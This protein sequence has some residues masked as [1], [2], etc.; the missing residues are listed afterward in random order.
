MIQPT[1]PALAAVARCRRKD[2]RPGELIEA[3][4]DV[5][6]ERGYAAA[7]LDDIAQRAGVTK[8]TVYLYFTDKEELFEAVVQKTLGGMVARGHAIAAGHTGRASD[9]LVEI[10]GHWWQDI[11]CDP[12]ASALPKLLI[13]EACNFPRLARAYYQIVIEPGRA[14]LREVLNR[15][16]DSGEFRPVSV[17]NVVQ[18]IIAPLVYRQCMQHSLQMAVPGMQLGDGEFLASF[19][20]HLLASLTARDHV[21]DLQ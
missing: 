1:E 16:I 5:F 21:R 2:A 18:F 19:K 15:G 10:L 6:V 9:L 11:V 12:R 17:D 4:L 13:A 14:L 20:D 7:R 3:A 8:G